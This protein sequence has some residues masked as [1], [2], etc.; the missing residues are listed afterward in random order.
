M[1]ASI[2]DIHRAMQSGKLTC[3][4]L[5]QQYLDRI[6]AYD[7]QG[8]AINAMLYVNPKALEQAEAMDKVFKRGAKLK[9]LQCIPLVLKDLFDT[10]DMPT[11][12]G[13][14]ALKG[15]QPAEDAFTVARLR[16]AGALILGKANLHELALTG[17]TVGDPLGWAD[18]KSL[19]ADAHAGR[20]FRRHRR[21]L[22]RQLRYR[23]HRFGHGK[24]DPLRH[25][26]LTASW[27]FVQRA[28]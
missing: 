12:G 8:P 10:A 25:P 13:S 11:T 27:A 9:P 20:V 23:G 19:R 1:E 24:L 21:C 26:Q 2:S 15:M 16:Q 28:G 7:Q 22:G 6:N 5:V 4:S 17:I 18:E 3:R 14:L